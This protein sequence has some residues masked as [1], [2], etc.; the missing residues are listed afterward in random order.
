MYEKKSVA[1]FFLNKQNAARPNF[2]AKIST[3]FQKNVKK[4]DIFW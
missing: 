1:F 3:D 2:S 4:M